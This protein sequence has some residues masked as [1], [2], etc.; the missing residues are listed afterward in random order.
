MRLRPFTMDDLGRI[1]QQ[2]DGHPDVWKFDPGYPPTREQRQRWLR[3][4][5]QELQVFSVGCLALELKSSGE[6]IGCCGL[7]FCLFDDGTHH[8]PEIEIYYRLGRDYWGCGYAT[9]AARE[10]LRYGFED[11]RLERIIAQ[12]SAENA[13]SLAVMRRLGMTIEPHPSKGGE[14][15][16]VVARAAQCD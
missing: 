10:L 2:F 5:I 13:A 8:R 11:L 9:E 7:E 4:R 12:A 1:H 15:F 14:V 6:L 16:G 3:F